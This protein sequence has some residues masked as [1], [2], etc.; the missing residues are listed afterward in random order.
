M[1]EAP[2]LQG[3][4]TVLVGATPVKMLARCKSLF[5]PCLNATGAQPGQHRE[6]N[7]MY[8]GSATAIHFRDAENVRSTTQADG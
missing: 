7:A 4:K 2:S 8:P 6:G 5:E 1:K 3:F